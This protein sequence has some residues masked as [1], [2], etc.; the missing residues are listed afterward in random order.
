MLPGDE[1]EAMVDADLYD[2][3]REVGEDLALDRCGRGR[4]GLVDWFL[5]GRIGCFGAK[6]VGEVKSS[7]SCV[8]VWA[9]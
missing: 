6:L 1:S 4:S 9:L 2:R 3:E 8:I 7:L 5:A